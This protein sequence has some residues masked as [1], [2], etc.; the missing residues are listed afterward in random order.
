[1]MCVAC[2]CA[3]CLCLFVCVVQRSCRHAPFCGGSGVECVACALTSLCAAA[4]IHVPCVRRPRSLMT[5]WAVV[6]DVWFLEP[7]FQ[8]EDE[9]A[10]QFASRVQNMIAEKA[11]LKSVAWDG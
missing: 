3:R 10:E 4:P 5:S 8:R 2:V 1:M 6:C 9:T 11:G 7:Q